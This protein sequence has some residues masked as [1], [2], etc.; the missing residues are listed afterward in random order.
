MTQAYKLAGALLATALKIEPDAVD[1]GAALGITPEWD[2]LAHMRLILAL[3]ER[4][5]RQLEPETIVGITNLDQIAA[6]LAADSAD[7]GI[8]SK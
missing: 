5:G 1:A 4:L 2:S 6:L 3:E 8:V 7:I